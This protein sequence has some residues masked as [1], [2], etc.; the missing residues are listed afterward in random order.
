MRIVKIKHNI[1]Q[2]QLKRTILLFVFVKIQLNPEIILL[3]YF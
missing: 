1:T 3:T 2:H